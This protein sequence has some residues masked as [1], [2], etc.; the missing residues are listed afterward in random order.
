MDLTRYAV[1][2]HVCVFDVNILAMTILTDCRP[3]FIQGL[4][5]M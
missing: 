5:G 3:S 1:N 4:E 2:G